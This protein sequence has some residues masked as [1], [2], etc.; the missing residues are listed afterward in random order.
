MT[1]RGLQRALLGGVLAVSAA[2]SLWWMGTVPYR[3][4]AVLDAVPEQ[5]AWVSLHASPAAR[6]PD[7]RSN[8]LVRAL[9]RLENMDL[10]KLES[11]MARF[12]NRLL[13]A[14]LG[15]REAAVAY[16]PAMPGS[17]KPA[18]VIACWAGGGSQQLRWVLNLRGPKPYIDPSLDGAHPIWPFRVAGWPADRRLSVAIRE[19]LV[20]AAVSTEPIAVRDCLAAAE[21]MP[22]CRSIRGSG[23][24]AQWARVEAPDRGWGRMPGMGDWTW[25]SDRLTA[26][27]TRLTLHPIAPE[28]ADVVPLFGNR[29][30]L[31]TLLDEAEG[32][33][34]VSWPRLRDGAAGRGGFWRQ[35]ADDWIRETA[36]TDQVRIVAALYGGAHGARIRSLFGG[37]IESFIQGLKVPTFL[38]AVPAPDP[39]AAAA[40]TARLL[41]RVNSR[42][43][44]GL[45]PREAGICFGRTVTAID[46]TRD[47]FYADLSRRE[48]IAYT[49]AGCC[50]VATWKRSRD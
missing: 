10:V 22:A 40:A 3:P 5:A 36:G 46:G 19:G 14:R 41:D 21:G 27:E 28:P 39:A 1:R 8:S 11:W 6:W 16:V 31:K 37:G 38:L 44:Y 23:A 50:W 33:V 30:P 48:Q 15:S 25:A 45:V 9:A 29:A 32:W 13:V 47:G 18:W 26:R 2:A 34:S 43:P 17:G 4:R 7:L 24:A 35:A 12:P 49:T 42:R 20:L